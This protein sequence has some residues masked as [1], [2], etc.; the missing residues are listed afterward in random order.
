MIR[1]VDE[2]ML[3]PS[4]SAPALIDHTYGPVPVPPFNVKPLL[5]AAPTSP[6]DVRVPLSAGGTTTVLVTVLLPPE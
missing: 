4:G 3:R 6:G 5:Y 2:L 1:P